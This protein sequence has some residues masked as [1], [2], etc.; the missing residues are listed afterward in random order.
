MIEAREPVMWY[1]DLCSCLH[2]TI[3]GV[4]GGYGYDPVSTLGAAWRFD[5]PGEWEPVEFAWPTRGGDLAETLVPYDDVRLVWHAPESE[6]AAEQELV[7]RLSAGQPLIVAV[8][9][10]YLPFR[11]AWQDV[12]AGHLVVVFGFDEAADVYLVHDAVPPAYQGP[13]AGSHLRASRSSGNPDEADPFF[14]GR[15][16]RRRWLEAAPRSQPAALDARRVER[17][18]KGNLAH[19]LADDGPSP[20]GLASARAYLDELPERAR[21]SSGSALRE[22][23]AFGWAPQA[24]AALHAEFLAQ[25]GSALRLPQLREAGRA[26][27]EVAHCWTP[28]RVGAAHGISAPG[29]TADYL[30]ARARTLLRRYEAALD[31]V[32]RA[33]EA[34]GAE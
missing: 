25:S 8:D 33:L 31:E 5:G 17:I 21:S 34:V 1:H 3:G 14:A 2:S 19:F 16:I 26:V 30:R 11:P 22:A 20:S 4:L 13:L 23:Y 7:A 18:L 27:E 12:H 6:A 28:L 9:N 10:F 24:S 29:D 32:E 15:P